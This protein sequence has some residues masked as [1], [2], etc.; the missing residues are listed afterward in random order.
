MNASP[1]QPSSP[2]APAAATARAARRTLPAAAALAALALAAGPALAS[3]AQAAE[4]DPSIAALSEFE[5]YWTPA[6]YDKADPAGTAFRGSVTQEGTSMLGQNDRTLV[7]INNAADEAQQ[8]RALIDAD[9]DWKQTLPDSLG[10]VLGKYFAE[11]LEDGSLAETSKAIQAAGKAAS[12]GDAKKHFNY[13]RPFM[14]DRSL[15]GKNDL[16]GLE[17][18]LGIKKVADWTDPETK[19]SHTALYDGMVASHSQAFPSGHTT[20]AYQVGLELS[21]LVPQLAPEVLT[22]SSEA[23]NNR[24]VLGVHYPM[25][26]MGGRILSHM[27]MAQIFSDGTYPEDTIKPAQSELQAY[28]A[29]RC[30]A[31][32]LGSDLES[33]ID[34]TGA[35]GAKG[36][37]NPAVDEVSK[38]PVTDRAS[39]LTAFRSRMTY[40]FAKVGKAGAAPEVPAQAPALLTSAFPTLN[41]DQ[42]REVLAATEIDSGYLFDASS[43][44]WQRIDL[45]AATSSKVTLS[46]DGTVVKV[47][48]GQ[49]RA[50]VVTEAAPTPTSPAPSPS[51][52]APAPAPSRTSGPAPTEEPSQ[53]PT[54][55]APTTSAPA[56][57]PKPG[58]DGDDD[59][60]SGP[61]KLPRTGAEL[62]AALAAA[63]AAVGLGGGLVA[64]TRRRKRAERD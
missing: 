38:K 34:K 64:L 58:D 63:A 43:K 41:E 61:G 3:P 60:G 23:G 21:M 9:E 28:L 16:R 37:A 8:H 31:D 52:S 33:C 32:D 24:V 49:S 62:G 14:D 6:P 18:K 27:K 56:P 44:G 11:G 35:A 36:Y 2:V 1:A 5:S 42:R 19:K 30:K 50:S 59:N 22:R 47:E 15:D 54:A 48:P 51:D 7:A 57:A 53:S 12:T 55:S 29:K 26:I 25:D 13:P 20:Y 46:K 40:G 10:P 39:A 17:K 4:T 45:P